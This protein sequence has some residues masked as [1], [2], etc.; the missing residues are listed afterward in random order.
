MKGIG[1]ALQGKRLAIIPPPGGGRAANL[2]VRTGA[3]IDVI[4]QRDLVDPNKF[5]ARNYPCTFYLSGEKYVASVH[6]PHDAEDALLAYLKQG[7]VLVV[8][9]CGPFPFHYDV[10]TGKAEVFSRKLGLPVRGGFEKPPEALAFYLN[11]D[12]KI[13]TGVPKEFPF[14]AEGDLRYR[15]IVRQG[16]SAEDVY[17]PFVTLKNQTG[18][19]YGDGGAYVEYRTGELKG[20]R[21]IYVWFRLLDYPEVGDQIIHSLLSWI[22]KCQ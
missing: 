11:V 6:K 5:N 8:L 15:P 13:V 2:L 12:Q 16:L 20:A 4:H 22:S 3:A 18:K 21:L 10:R 9:P 19:D 14:P 7:G 1:S 17:I